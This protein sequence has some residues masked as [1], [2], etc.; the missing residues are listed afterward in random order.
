MRETTKK[1]YSTDWQSRKATK[2]AVS[3]FEAQFG[4]DMG[5]DLSSAGLN[6]DYEIC[7]T[8]SLNLDVALTTG[9]MPT[10]R[11]VEIWGPEHA[12]KTTLACILAAMYQREFPDKK[13][14]WV[15]MEQT[16]DPKYARALGVDV[17]ALWRPVVK[18]AED[19]ADATKRFTESGLCSLVVLDSVGGMIAKMEL[20]KEAD[21][22]TVGLVAKVVTRMVKQVSPMAKS[23]GTTVCVINQVR[24]VIGNA[25]G[26]DET[27]SGG[28]ALKHV[29]TIRLRV[30]RGATRFVKVKGK[31]IPC[32][33]EMIVQVQKNKLGPYG[34]TARIWLSNVPTEKFGPVGVDVAQET[35][36]FAKDYG[37]FGSKAGGYYMFPD[38]ETEVRG[39]PAAVELL[40]QRE[41]FCVILRSKVLAQLEG[42]IMESDEDS[43]DE[44]D[45]F[46]KAMATS[47]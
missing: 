37:L 39:E 30:R 40:R 28:W 8:G 23:N 44:S 19:T 11:V 1:T 32:G 12:G 47:A 7:S 38:G 31:E 33:H 25:Y 34:Q 24:A 21:E 18:T 2:V 6:D 26:P 36:D 13:V 20:Q 5:I 4:K 16:F 22:A 42:T 29:T 45:P 15:D 27:T 9:G 17:E 35:F 46:V 3:K 43:E 14:A 10:G 41:D